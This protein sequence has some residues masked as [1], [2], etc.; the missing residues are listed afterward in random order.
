MGRFRIQILRNA[1]WETIYT[2]IKNEDFND[3][4]TTWSLL[5]IGY[6]TKQFWH[7]AYSRSNRH[8]TQ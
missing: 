6:Y 1:A 2:I 7:R 4:S 3:D 8:S 5:N